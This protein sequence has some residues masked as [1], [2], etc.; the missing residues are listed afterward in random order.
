[1]ES[2]CVQAPKIDSH[3]RLANLLDARKY[4]RSFTW[5]A[6][7]GAAS[8]KPVK[9]LSNSVFVGYLYRKLN[10]KK[11]KG[12][13]SAT[14][15]R[16]WNGTKWCYSGQPKKLKASQVYPRRFG[17]QAMLTELCT[18]AVCIGLYIMCL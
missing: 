16:Y 3:P 2:S 1:M 18:C 7:Y 10:R 14:T 11:L 4:Y 8:A 9:L 13:L 12:K 6:M 17:A 5:L 15:K